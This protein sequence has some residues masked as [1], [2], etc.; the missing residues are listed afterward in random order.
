MV[1]TNSYRDV[2]METKSRYEVIAELEKQKRDLIKERDGL[3]DTL[4][5]KSNELELLRKSRE[6]AIN[7]AER[8]LKDL[9]D[10]QFRES[11]NIDREVEDLNRKKEDLLLN[12]ESEK[13]KVERSKEDAINHHDRSLNIRTIELTNFKETLETRKITINELIKGVDESLE[14]FA[15]AQKTKN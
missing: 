8:S 4:L 12:I 9:G 10:K 6:D 2:K 5:N 14:R 1:Y 15:N 7:R 11:K 3:Q 13:E